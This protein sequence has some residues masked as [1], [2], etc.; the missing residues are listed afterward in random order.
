MAHPKNQSYEL[1]SLLQ[2]SWKFT[3][4]VDLNSLV[5][6]GKIVQKVSEKRA[7]KVSGIELLSFHFYFF[8]YN[9]TWQEKLA[10]PKPTK[11][12]QILV[13]LGKLY[14]SSLS[15]LGT[16][17]YFSFLINSSTSEPIIRSTSKTKKLKTILTRSL[18][19]QN[20]AKSKLSL[21]LN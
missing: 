4:F 1:S 11:M 14:K 8:T 18:I 5:F 13:N 21:F 10:P 2:V 16:T 12:T 7:E 6:S 15:P 20:H 9:K 19:K 17:P 3:I